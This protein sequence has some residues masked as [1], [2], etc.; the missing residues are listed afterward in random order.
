MATQA[1]LIQALQV[2]K[3]HIEET[4][5]IGLQYHESI[6]ETVNQIAATIDVGYTPL[7]SAM[8]LSAMESFQEVQRIVQG[9]ATEVGNMITM[10][11][12]IGHG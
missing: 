12:G 5:T 7:A 2:A 9:A 6:S 10:A 8:L 11:S 4:V 1:E 3:E